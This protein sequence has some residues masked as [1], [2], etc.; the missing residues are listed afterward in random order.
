MSCDLFAERPRLDGAILIGEGRRECAGSAPPPTTI[1]VRLREPRWWWSD[2]TL[3]KA[4]Q[5]VGSDFI[6]TVTVTYRCR[7]LKGR[8]VYTET[9]AKIGG[10]V[11]SPKV[12]VF[13]G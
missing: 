11:T 10:K 2:K 1:T 6:T 9:R 3:A 5:A 4:E 7:G 12:S 8:R 13:C